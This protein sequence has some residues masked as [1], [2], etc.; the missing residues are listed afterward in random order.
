MSW[1]I[2]YT[3]RAAHDPPRLTAYVLRF[4]RYA[5]GHGLDRFG[6][7]V[8]IVTYVTLSLYQLQLP[9]LHYDEAFEA[10]PA[11]QILRGQPVVAF[12]DG[13]LLL[14]RQ[15]YP[16]MTQDYIG[17]LNTYAVIPFILLFGATTTA[18]RVFS[19]IIGAITLLLAYHLSYQLSGRVQVGLS[20]ALL[21]AVDPTFVFWN[22][23]GIFVTAITATIGLGAAY[24]WLRRLQGG[25]R[26]WSIAGGF[27]FGLGIFAKLLFIWLILAL[28]GA[29]FLL[30]LPGLLKKRRRPAG[31]LLSLLNQPPIQ[32]KEILLTILAFVLGC[33]PLII[34][35]IQTSGTLLSITRNAQTS[36]YG[37]NNLAIGS[38]LVERSAQFVRL[39][40]GS[41][42]WYLGRIVSNPVS[43]AVFVIVLLS[44][45]LPN[46][47]TIRKQ[48]SP[49]PAG[50]EPAAKSALFP[51]LVVGLVILA[52]IQTVSALWVTHFAILMPWPA[53]AVALGSGFA[54]IRLRPYD[55]AYV[56]RAIIWSGLGLLIITNL[57]ST[58]RYHQA[59]TES[60]GLS[61]HS[62][63]IYD[64]SNWLDNR[65]A[66]E[67][68]AMDWGLAAPIFYLTGGQVNPIEVFGYAWQPD[69][70]LTARLTEFIE[71]PATYYLWRAPDEIIFDR[72]VEFKALYRPLH[73]EETIEEAFYERSGRP[74]LGVTR[75]VPAGTA[76][77]PP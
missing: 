23:Q 64:L 2:D 25:G 52:S 68:V 32:I 10:V 37:V 53:I 47:M 34:Y 50:D 60:G 66:G 58:L 49:P 29:L 48:N 70:E 8:I 11:L 75:L 72:S 44:V 67:V 40:D 65:A 9:G 69:G 51:F 77:N 20:A 1:F 17:A 59:L 63:A 22:R 71:Q 41:H 24:C 30:S 15:L 61:G 76:A 4:V 28:I 56:L 62:D 3:S 31:F 18:L 45:I 7:L 27:L 16:L 74:I 26:L 46:F 33:W 73:L 42:L 55:R 38:N 54:L 35:N 19:T 36:Y 57:V 5:L 13:G 43:I 12:R 39:L 14:G 6:L 21:L